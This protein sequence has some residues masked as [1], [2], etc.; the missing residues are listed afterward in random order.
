M[1]KKRTL[2][3]RESSDIGIMIHN[4][5]K[6]R[7]NAAWEIEDALRQPLSPQSAQ[8]AALIMVHALAQTGG[9][10]SPEREEITMHWERVMD[11]GSGLRFRPIVPLP[12]G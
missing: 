9:E 2:L 11:P 10:R 7:A 5:L 1:A 12:C 3:E 6:R 4:H 8:T